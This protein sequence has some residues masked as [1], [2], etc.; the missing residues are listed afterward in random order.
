MLSSARVSSIEIPD[1]VGAKARKG[2]DA[3]Q[4]PCLQPVSFCDAKYPETANFVRLIRRRVIFPCYYRRFTAPYAAPYLALG[5]HC[6]NTGK[7][8]S[9]YAALQSWPLD[10]NSNLAKAWAAIFWGFAYL[11]RTNHELVLI[12]IECR[13]L[14]LWFWSIPLDR[15]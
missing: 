11:L 15:A 3:M 9:I 2:R 13:F 6:I 7:L 12:C 8:T 4:A 14:H 1:F 10:A 5:Q